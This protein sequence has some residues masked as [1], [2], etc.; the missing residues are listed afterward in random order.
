MRARLGAGRRGA[1]MSSAQPQLI[2]PP[3]NELHVNGLRPTLMPKWLRRLL[4]GSTQPSGRVDQARDTD[5]PRW[6]LAIEDRDALASRLS[7]VA[8]KVLIDYSARG[9]RNRRGYP[10]PRTG[11]SNL[12]HGYTKTSLAPVLG[13]D[14]IF[15]QRFRLE[16]AGPVAN[17]AQFPAMT[18]LWH[19]AA[20]P[21]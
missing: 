18:A 7:C 1:D 8:G 6:R 3:A 13:H 19:N 10:T 12:E 14:W 5:A 17:S 4:T 15:T 2:S 21:V 16:V 11:C 9:Q 20:I